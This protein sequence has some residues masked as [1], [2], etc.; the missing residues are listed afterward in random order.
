MKEF[1]I[2]NAFS[3]WKKN[4]Y[5]GGSCLQYTD[6]FKANGAQFTLK[7]CIIS[8]YR[9]VYTLILYTSILLYM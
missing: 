4:R 6:V 7:V 8:L 5:T 1:T 3:I 9:S 2:I